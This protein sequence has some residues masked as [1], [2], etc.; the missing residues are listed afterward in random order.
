MNIP[1][2]QLGPWFR[3]R[4]AAREKLLT[5]F[6]GPLGRRRINKQRVVREGDRY[7]IDRG[8]PIAL[9]EALERLMRGK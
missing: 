7:V 6:S 8:K 3:S 9:D 1:P 5:M 4:R 2:A